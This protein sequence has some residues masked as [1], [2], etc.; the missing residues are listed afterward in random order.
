[1]SSVLFSVSDAVSFILLLRV[2]VKTTVAVILPNYSAE[3]QLRM[4][5]ARALRGWRFSVWRR[6]LLREA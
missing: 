1:M 3:L 6:A 5:G 4:D 2:D